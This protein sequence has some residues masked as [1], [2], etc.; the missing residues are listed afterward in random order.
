MEV[1][2][3]VKM[4]PKIMYNFMMNHTYR[5]FSGFLGVLFGIASFVMFGVTLGKTSVSFS[6]LYLLFGVWFVLYLPVNLYMRSNRQVKNSEV[7][8]KPITYV[9][10]DKG[11]QI[12]QGEDKADC[13][14]ENI[15]KVSKTGKSLLVYTGQRN[16]FVLPKEA[17][18]DQYERLA[19]LFLKN[20]PK[21]KVKL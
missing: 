3:E 19:A 12:I 13:K 9:V 17:I 6:I 11:I 15:R 18:G 16:A 14:W 4:T 8:K 1:R 21:G 7:F 5:S 2:F 20:M 10:S